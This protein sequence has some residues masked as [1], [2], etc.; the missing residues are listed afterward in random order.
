V[1]TSTLPPTAVAPADRFVRRLLRVGNESSTP[2]AAQKALQTSLLISTVRCTVM[3]VILPFVAPTLGWIGGV[4]TAVSV[5][6]SVVAMAS[7]VLSMRRF[8]RCNHPKR[9]AYTWFGGAFFVG[10]AVLL[11]RD[12]VQLLG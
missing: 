3:Y 9:W 2:Q 4:S 8:W 6:I 5:V 12:L 7:I 10:L 1:P 11:V